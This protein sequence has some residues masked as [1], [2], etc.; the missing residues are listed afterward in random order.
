MVITF[1]WPA[2]AAGTA[3]FLLISIP[4]AIIAA[5]MGH[6]LNLTTRSVPPKPDK[7]SCFDK[8]TSIE[9]AN[10]FIKIS[11]LKPGMILKNG[12]K[13]AAT[14]K[15]ALNNQKMFNINNIIVSDNHKIFHDKYGWIRVDKHPDAVLIKDYRE[16][17]IYCL[18]T[19]TKRIVI[20][21]TAFLDWDELEP[22]DIIKLKE[23]K[24]LNHN[25]SISNV[26]K[27]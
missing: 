24:L 20:N 5:Y 7:P 18:N 8:N 3:F 22:M 4:T 15:C 10:G 19:E 13:I 23:F 27:K 16:E 14:F 9:T 26:H 2:A 11:K 6:I 21:N 12:E 1:T 17:F 25:C